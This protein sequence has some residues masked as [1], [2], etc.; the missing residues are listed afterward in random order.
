MTD[1]PISQ[2]LNG[3]ATMKTS[4]IKDISRTLSNN[5]SRFIAIVVMVALG[6][7]VFTGF[8]AGC[9][10]AFRSADLFFTKQNM[11]D[12]KLVSTLGLTQ[13]DLAVA[14]EVDGVAAVF[15]NRS[16]DVKYGQSNGNSFVAN[17]TTLD[18]YGMNEPYVLEGAL[19]VKSGQIA[20]N[21]KFLK[22]TGLKLGDVITLAKYDSDSEA[23]EAVIDSEEE[24]DDVV[25]E[26]DTAGRK[27][28][29]DTGSEADAADTDSEADSTSPE[30]DSKASDKI[31]TTDLVD[32]SGAG[33]EGAT[34]SADIT[35]IETD[36][37]TNLEI[38]VDNASSE[39]V[40]AVTEYV[41]TAVILSP[42]DISN[43]EGSLAL[44]SLST[45]SSDYMLYATADCIDSDIYTAIY[46]TIEGASELDC[47][48]EEYRTL[49]EQMTGKLEDTIQAEREQARYDEVVGEANAKIAEAE[50]LLADKMAEAKQKLTDAQ[51]EIDDGWIEIRDG[52]EELT[53]NEKKLSDGE[54][55]L[56]DAKKSAEEKLSAAQ[57]E[58]NSNLAEL[59]AAEEE[60]NSN[61]AAALE[62]FEDYEQQLALGNQELM[63]QQ[64]EAGKQLDHTIA[65]LTEEAGQVWS[66]KATQQVWSDMIK[67]G[68]KAAPYLIAARQGETP[69]EEQTKAYNL[70]MAAL[71]TDTQTLAGSFAGAGAPL[72]EEQIN[73]FSSLAVTLG[74]IEY[75]QREAEARS[76]QL[77]KEK[78]AAL[79]QISEGRQEI[80]DGKAKLV[81]GQ[82]KLDEN[83][84]ATRKQ[85]AEK[86]EEFKEGRQE[87]EAAKADLK[88][89]EEKLTDGQL[90]LDRNLSDYESSVATASQKLADAKEEVADI[91]M[92]RWY[93]W[94][95]YDNDGFSGLDSDISFIQE[96]TK[97]FPFIFFLVAILI[98]LTTMTR[99][100]EEDRGLIGTYKSLGY[101]K[102][103][104]SLKYVFYSIL[105]CLSGGLLGSV[106]GLYGLP[107]IIEIIVSTLYVLP[108]FQLSFYP[109]YSLG[110]FGLFLLGI[111]GATVISCA[112][113]L[114]MRPAEL[115]R[116]KSP[117][118]GSRILLERIPFVWKRLSFLR[119]VTCRNLFR[120][121]KRALM[122]IVG[123]LGCTMLIVFAF[124][125]RNTVGV[126]MS[127]QFDTITVYD[128]IVVTDDLNVEEAEALAQEWKASDMV[129]GVLQLQTTTLKLHTGS[130]SME[131]TAMIL[132]DDAKLEQYIHLYD[133]ASGQAMS[134]PA[135]GIVLTTNAAKQLELAAADRISLQT[136]DN[137]EYDFKISF[138]AENYAGNYIYLSESSYQEAFGSYTA[139]SF[140]VNL[141]EQA[142]EQNW[143]DSLK[144][145]KRILTVSDNEEV[146]N[147]FSDVNKI[148]SMVVY[149]LIGMSA[150]LAVAV[151]FTLSN[152]NISERE[153]ELATVKV[154]GFLPKEVFSYVNKETMILTLFGI[155]LGMP[156]GY[157]ITYAILSNVNIADVAF[158]VRVSAGAYLIAAALTL[159]FT[160]LVNL[161][162]NK[163]LRGINMVEALK[164]VE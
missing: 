132:P 67:D 7:G 154:L 140:L 17:L 109:G 33:T 63:Q 20:V 118:A 56:A 38:T 29:T 9:L 76:E 150:V 21:S 143:L 32:M 12:I 25:S 161:I 92:T 116:P 84:A 68:A 126:L 123:I 26:V 61:E 78:T 136:D 52:W 155:L 46:L 107:K 144:N 139:N 86:E 13:E 51:T 4:Y 1:L 160:L 81:S 135:D 14:S 90:E 72:T 55:A 97:A 101:S 119:K 58:I 3:D 22:D 110:G 45:S 147:S 133:K 27:D 102:I 75:S 100:V 105:A 83:R 157:G 117:K 41:I 11:Y 47:Y 34:D 158:R 71:Q 141:T 2:K 79:T 18:A 66:M 31:N 28:T 73:T 74:T 57:E 65:A 40:L 134:L 42:L 152:I 125:I 142:G 48:S 103:Q 35:D 137:K 6:T 122:T 91:V 113:M 53:A 156:A 94:D 43:K 19:P 16:M 36:T 149:L 5:R 89:G 88:E 37:D 87:L 64:S 8:A 98:S 104:I 112:E 129:T 128:A 151:L 30:V 111:V 124:G 23:D 70:A 108:T 138:V 146:R 148:V 153:R 60:L 106:L 95:R 49:V 69:T 164:S 163:T 93:L 24:T 145:D 80:Q 121:K 127:D 82:K 10:N 130:G 114:H 131:L 59:V 120:Y 162:T 54:Q 159:I 15:G 85:L 115:M 96:I 77:A 50:A 39:P 62:K 99:M 44:V